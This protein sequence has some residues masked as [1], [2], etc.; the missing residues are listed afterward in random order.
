MYQLNTGDGVKMKVSDSKG[1]EKVKTAALCLSISIVAMVLLGGLAMLYSSA[2]GASGAIIFKKQM[3]WA[4]AGIIGAV[5]VYM[6]GYR[7]AVKYSLVF[8]VISVILLIL[9]RAS[10]PVDGAYTWVLLPG[11]SIQPSEFAKISLILF[12]AHFC[13]VKQELLNS[14]S[15]RIIPLFAAIAVVCGLLFID[16]DYGTAVL[17]ASTAVIMLFAARIKFAYLMVGTATTALIFILAKHMY[18]GMAAKRGGYQTWNALMD[19]GSGSWGGIGLIV[20]TLAVLGYVVIALLSIYISMKS[21][22][23]QGKL[24]GLGITAMITLQALMNVIFSGTFMGIG[25]NAPFIG[26]GGSNLMMSLVCV[27]LI[28][29]IAMDDGQSEE[30][31]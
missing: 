26:Y 7:N 12:I 25:V 19:L 17:L 5:A 29:S 6:Y 13:S 21:E 4:T 18:P 11:L 2:I 20:I 22:N 1:D 8:L 3:I 30:L 9:A 10:A 27:G 15:L 31:Q 28:L 14:F 16:K 23:R 24:L